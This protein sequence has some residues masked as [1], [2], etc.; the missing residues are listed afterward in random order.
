MYI[1][2]LASLAHPPPPF[3]GG[4][5]SSRP[6]EPIVPASFC[7]SVEV[8]VATTAFGNLRHTM[9][10]GTY[11]VAVGI[12]RRLVV[13]QMDRQGDEGFAGKTDQPEDGAAEVLAE[14]PSVVATLAG[15]KST[16]P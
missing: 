9:R 1:T 8:A 4:S 14:A 3:Q 16:L 7:M 11:S 15:S 2:S 6:P 5:S 12:H 10:I 13:P